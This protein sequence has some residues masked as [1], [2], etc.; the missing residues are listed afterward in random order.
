LQYLNKINKNKNKIAIWQEI[1][2]L[3]DCK[4]GAQETTF[5]HHQYLVL[6]STMKRV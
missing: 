5:T 4:C 2:E 3:R 1:H 6:A